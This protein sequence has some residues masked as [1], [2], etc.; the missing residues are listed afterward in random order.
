MIKSEGY[1]A[2]S[3]PFYRQTSALQGKGGAAAAS[4]TPERSNGADVLTARAG[5][6]LP[7][8][9][10]HGEAGVRSESFP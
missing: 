4:D 10:P 9:L 3:G 1:R 7:G 5:D 8:P 6:S 2:A